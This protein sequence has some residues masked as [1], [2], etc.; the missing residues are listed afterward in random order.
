MPKKSMK[1]LKKNK[2]GGDDNE[3]SVVPPVTEETPVDE[4][5]PVNETPVNETPVNETPVN[6]TPVPEE[7]TGGKKRSKKG[8]KKSITLKKSSGTATAYCVKCKKMGSMSNSHTKT[9][10]N[11]RNMLQGTC[12]KCGTKMNKFIK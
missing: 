2:K 10:K 5:T 8:G 11:G 12:P 7:T 6:E 3:T 4:K 9:S 1:S